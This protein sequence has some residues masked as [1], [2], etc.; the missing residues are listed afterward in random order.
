MHDP[1]ITER[2]QY[3]LDRFRVTEAFDR[4]IADYARSEEPKPKEPYS[5]K[6]ILARRGLLDSASAESS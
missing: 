2:Q 6:C 1:P 3:W 4:S 5:W